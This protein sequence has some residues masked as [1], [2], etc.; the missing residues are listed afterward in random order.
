MRVNAVAPPAT[1]SDE[2]KARIEAG[3]RDPEK[4]DKE[5][6]IPKAILPEDVAEGIFF[7]C[8]EAAHAITGATLPIDY[9]WL[10]G[11]TYKAYP[12]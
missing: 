3:E 2:M 1:L 11:V 6:A 9:G 12:R 7:L 4:P 5:N 8:S 10:V